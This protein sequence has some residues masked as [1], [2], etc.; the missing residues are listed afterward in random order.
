M[1][2]EYVR[3]RRA[4]WPFVL[5]G[6]FA[7]IVFTGAVILIWSYLV[8]GNEERLHSEDGFAD[9]ANVVE[10][11]RGTFSYV[12]SV[13]NG[14]VRLGNGETRKPE[15]GCSFVMVVRFKYRLSAGEMKVLDSQLDS[16]MAE[17]VIEG[18]EVFVHGAVIN[19][20]CGPRETAPD[21]EQWPWKEVWRYVRPV[22]DQRLFEQ[23]QRQ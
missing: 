10:C 23:S 2:Q 14:T 9:R 17:G 5:G 7:G 11:K 8:E 19:K 18:R 15:S 6:S 4:K 12:A 13:E 3:K 22:M 21:K 20:F 16:L 1:V